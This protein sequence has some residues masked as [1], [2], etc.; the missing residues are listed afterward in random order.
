MNGTSEIETVVLA[1]SSDAEERCRRVG[2]LVAAVPHRVD[3]DDDV[4]DALGPVLR[5][6]SALLVGAPATHAAAPWVAGVL[7]D[8]PRH[9]ASLE[10]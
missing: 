5:E 10:A 8:W 9:S 2:P 4:R 1:P 6:L 7:P 3:V